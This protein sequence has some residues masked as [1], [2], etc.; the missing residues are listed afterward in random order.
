M[1]SKFRPHKTTDENF[2]CSTCHVESAAL[3]IVKARQFGL[4]QLVDF[5]RQF[6]KARFFVAG[7]GWGDKL[8][9]REKQ[10]F[11]LLHI[12]TNLCSKKI[13]LR[14]FS[15]LEHFRLKNTVLKLS[16]VDLQLYKSGRLIE[17]GG[18]L[19]TPV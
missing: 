6:C 10:R 9:F 8:A 11:S 13:W 16:S 12:G 18:G 3:S 5:S 19:S 14:S 4:L 15:A 1:Q 17:G 7:R 2:D